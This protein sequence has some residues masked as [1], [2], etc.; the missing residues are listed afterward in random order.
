MLTLCSF[1]CIVFDFYFLDFFGYFFSALSPF[2]YLTFYSLVCLLFFFSSLFIYF[3][4]ER[5]HARVGGAERERIPSR[6]HTVSMEPDAGLKLT[7][8]EVMT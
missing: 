1:S 2:S 5:E 3:E 7:N 6:P 8:R 4:R